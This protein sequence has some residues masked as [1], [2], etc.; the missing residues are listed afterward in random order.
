MKKCYIIMTKLTRKVDN[1]NIL[2]NRKFGIHGSTYKENMTEK[3]NSKH[4][5]KIITY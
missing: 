2:F 5:I 4:R 1:C 3:I